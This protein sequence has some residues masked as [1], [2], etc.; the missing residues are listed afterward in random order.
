MTREQLKSYRSK[1]E[2]IAELEEKLKNLLHALSA[3]MVSMCSESGRT[4]F[5]QGNE[6]PQNAEYQK[7]VHI[8]RSD[9]FQYGMDTNAGNAFVYGDMEPVDTVTFHDRCY[10]N[11]GDYLSLGYLHGSILKQSCPGGYSD[12]RGNRR[13]ISVCGEGRREI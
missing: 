7:A 8:E 9:L 12:I 4:I 11:A 2:E 10:C 3:L 13:G 1:K 5:P 6:I